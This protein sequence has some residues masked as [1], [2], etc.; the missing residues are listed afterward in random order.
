MD[1]ILKYEKLV[2]KIASRYSYHSNF[3]DLKQVGMIGLLKAVD[4]YQ[5]N[6]NTKFSTYAFLWIRGEI[7]EYLRNDKNVKF[8]KEILSLSRKLDSGYEELRQILG[9]EP[10]IQEVATYL[11][12]DEKNIIDAINAKEFIFSADY[13]LNQDE[14]G[15]AVS[16]YDMV[17]YYEKGYDEDI[18]TLRSALEDLPEEEKNI[19]QLRYFQDMS[20]SEV[21]KILGTNQVNISRHESKILQKLRKDKIA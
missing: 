8:S 13:V 5:P 14:E 18:L 4:N 16:L 12:T 2:C 9:R 15:K 7:L 6:C 11:E 17:P 20:Q 1:N 3:E 21:S 10:S 19:I